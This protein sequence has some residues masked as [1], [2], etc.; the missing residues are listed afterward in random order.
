MLDFRQQT[1]LHF[2]GHVKNLG[3]E[4]SVKYYQKFEFQLGQYSQVSHIDL[5]WHMTDES[6]KAGKYPL[7]Q[8]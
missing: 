3:L 8:S 1:F 2:L 4:E 6:M 5:A 7:V